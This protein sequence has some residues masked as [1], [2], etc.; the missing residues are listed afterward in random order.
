MK[1]R[2][3]EHK[4]AVVIP[5]YNAA[6]EI[7]KVVN[8]LPDFVD[9]I[10]IV[11]D[12]SPETLPTDKLKALSVASKLVMLENEENLGVGGATKM[13]FVR[14]I[15]DENDIVIKVDADDQ[16][17]TSYMP[18]LIDA[19][20]QN[21]CEVAKGNRFTDFKALNKMPLVRKI[22]NLGLSFLTKM[23]TGYWNNFDPTNGFFAVRTDL[24]KRVDLSKVANRYYFET[25]L[26]AEFYYQN[27]RIKDV[28][29]P[30]IYGDEKSNM[31][32]WKMPFVFLPKLMKTFFKRIAKTYFLY[33]F[34]VSSLYIL[35]GLPAFLFGVI[36][37]G[38]KWWYFSSRDLFA[39]TGTIMV[40]TLS[41]ILGFQLL[42]QA[43]QFD[44][45]RA[46][47]AEQ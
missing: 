9:S 22:G 24:L 8:G 4:I 6:N 16:M 25:S 47:K 46:P 42:L 28:A 21:K 10:V 37:G 38:Y 44:I 35:F 15:N 27:A 43:T 3:P 41:I 34:N 31:T 45:M 26:I 14:A 40:V 18:Q 7:V 23:A 36:Y 12:K 29:M 2:Y 19:I 17:D 1:Q 11:D 30:A 13:G 20:I 5:Y 32:V 39:P 33:D